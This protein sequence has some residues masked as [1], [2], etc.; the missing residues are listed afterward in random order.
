M[1]D[2]IRLRSAARRRDLVACCGIGALVAGLGGLFSAAGHGVVPVIM[3]VA[4]IITSLAAIAGM[5]N[6]IRQR[7]WF[8]DTGTGFVLTD[9]TGEHAVSDREVLSIALI[10][11]QNYEE[12]FAKSTTHRLLIWLVSHD[13]MPARLEM[14]NTSQLNDSDP[15][16]ALATR[17]GRQLFDQARDEW[18]A[19]QSVLGERWSLQHQDVTVREKRE[20][21]SCRLDDVA[22]VDSVGEHLCIWL[23]GADHAWARIPLASANLYVLQRFLQE[24]LAT[25]PGGDSPPKGLGRIIFERRPNKRWAVFLFLISI[26]FAGFAVF[27]AVEAP[28]MNRKLIGS[29]GFMGAAILSAVTGLHMALGL[30]RCHEYGASQAGLFG[31]RTLRY[32]EVE[33]YCFSAIRYYFNGAYSGM[34]F[35]MEL[36]PIPG[37]GVPPIRLTTSL[38]HWDPEMDRIQNHLARIIA[39]RMSQ[40]LKAGEAVPWTR[41]LRILPEGLEFRR[42]GLFG[43]KRPQLIRY[44][45]IGSFQM[46]QGWF[47]LWVHGQ[48]KPLVE[49]PVS[50]RNFLA[51]YLLL[52]DLTRPMA[53]MEGT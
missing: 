4:G 26:L 6:S 28:D 27:A 50:A 31:V 12:G 3:I 33:S 45:E 5:V 7:Q 40:K 51:G 9:R 2:M 46:N 53:Q 42:R 38:S 35:K 47:Y 36:Y 24:Y 20:T 10:T 25:K 41:S 30:F 11:R 34:N 19:G 29:I 48:K 23:K 39:G 8:R 37:L 43:R 18:N 32:I 22:Y 13:D 17:L 16:Y 1:S 44:G 49:I 15:L 21:K 14:T 52:A